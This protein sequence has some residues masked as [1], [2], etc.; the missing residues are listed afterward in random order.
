[1]PS[2][3]ALSKAAQAWCTYET[4]G[5]QMDERLATAF[6]AI[7]DEVWNQPWLGN[8]TTAQLIDEL[9]CRCEVNGTINYRTVD[10]Y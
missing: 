4:S 3:L 5:I 8:A 2:N 10:K 9:R 6:A 7:L 1:M